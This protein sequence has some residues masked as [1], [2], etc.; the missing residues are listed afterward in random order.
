MREQHS[1]HAAGQTPY[2][3]AID[4]GRARRSD[5]D[6]LPAP[7]LLDGGRLS[8][9][10]A[11]FAHCARILTPARHGCGRLTTAAWDV[12][13]IACVET[14]EGTMTV[15]SAAFTTSTMTAAIRLYCGPR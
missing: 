8:G 15:P 9:V 3:R 4:Q 13:H 6:R 12:N 2:S 5:G 14:E 10:P 11:M 7:R 1:R